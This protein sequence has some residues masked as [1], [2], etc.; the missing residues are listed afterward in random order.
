MER[1]MKKKTLPVF[2]IILALL[3]TS[4][5]AQSD[6]QC[7]AV[8][9]RLLALNSENPARNGRIYLMSAAEG[10]IEYF[11][12]EDKML[13]YGENA[14]KHCFPKIED[15]AI[16]VSVRIP[17]EIGVFKCYSSSD[18]DIVA[19][20]C[21]ERADMIK[22]TLRDSQWRQKSENIRVCV[23]GHFVLFIFSDE[24]QRIESRF[25]ELV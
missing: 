16:F 8:L 10:Q 11:S 12:E 4:C 1:F 13:M 20:M 22:V 3:L 9:S 6:K 23:H 18:T 25:R 17:E 24:P 5:S 2:L 15:C 14:Y 7:D 19:R 21:L